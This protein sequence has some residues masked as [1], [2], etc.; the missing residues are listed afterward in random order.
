MTNCRKKT[1]HFFRL[2]KVSLDSQCPFWAL[3]HLCKNPQ[4]CGICPCEDDIIPEKWK[5]ED[6]KIHENNNSK[7]GDKMGDINL[8]QMDFFKKM[9]MRP[10]K[11]HDWVL[12][13]CDKT[14]CEYIDLNK[15][16][17]AYTG[18]QGQNIWKMIY[19]DNCFTSKITSLKNPRTEFMLGGKSS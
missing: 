17:E 4:T 7:M 15:N 16:V 19:K 11:P 1:T 3:D 9:P 8:S 18:Y 2:Y 5:L 6:K 14:Q 12:S 10:V 13:D